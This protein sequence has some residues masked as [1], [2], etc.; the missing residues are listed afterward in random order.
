MKIRDIGIGLKATLHRTRL[1]AR[2]A[3]GLKP[4][5]RTVF[6]ANSHAIRDFVSPLY[7]L[8][9][10]CRTDSFRRQHSYMKVRDVLSKS[11]WRGYRIQRIASYY[12]HFSPK[13]L[14]L[15]GAYDGT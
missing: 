13:Y 1:I 5:V 8:L 3:L 10:G 12:K 2:D 14:R 4:Q 9:C 6:T 15:K 11:V 7:V